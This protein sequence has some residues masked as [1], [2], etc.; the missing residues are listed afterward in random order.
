MFISNFINMSN[1]YISAIVILLISVLKVFKIEVASDAITGIVT[2]LLAV[3][4]AFRRY[5]KGDIS[6]L[7][8]RK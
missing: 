4:I 8:V 3:W 7:G 6:L 1:E 5:Q 2:G